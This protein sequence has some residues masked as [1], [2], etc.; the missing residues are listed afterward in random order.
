MKHTFIECPNCGYEYD[1]DY[2]EGYCSLC[3]HKVSDEYIEE[4]ITDGYYEIWEA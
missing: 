3:Q 2:A 1:V 4:C